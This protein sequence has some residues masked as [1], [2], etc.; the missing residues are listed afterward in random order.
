[1]S[2]SQI[3]TDCFNEINTYTYIMMRLHTFD[4]QLQ[5]TIELN[6]M[7]RWT[8]YIKSKQTLHYMHDFETYVKSC[9]NSLGKKGDS[10]TFIDL[11]PGNYTSGMP[12]AL[13]ASFSIRITALLLVHQL[14]WLSSVGVKLFVKK[15][16]TTLLF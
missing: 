12:H 11:C 13:L 10:S 8:K 4:S 6:K 14:F 15:Q 7:E 5:C 1:M 16:P 9:F 3:C 2:A